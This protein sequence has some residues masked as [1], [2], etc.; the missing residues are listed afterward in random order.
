MSNTELYWIWIACHVCFR[1]TYYRQNWRNPCNTAWSFSPICVSI[2]TLLILLI[3][4]LIVF[5]IYYTWYILR[6]Y[7]IL[8][9]RFLN[10]EEICNVFCS[11]SLKFQQ[12][13]SCLM[14]INSITFFPVV[15]FIFSYWFRGVINISWRLILYLLCSWKISSN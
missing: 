14:P 8:V 15:L 5:Y 12:L 1:I 6:Q 10:C 4:F 11:A 9:F 2:T 3:S 7:W 13:L